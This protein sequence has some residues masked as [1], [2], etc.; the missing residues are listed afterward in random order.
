VRPLRARLETSRR[1][2]GLPWEV[3]EEIVAEKLRAL[4]QHARSL[5]ERGWSRSR[6]RDYYDLWRI[7][8]ACRGDLDL[9]GFPALLERKCAVR[10]VAF[11]GV[12]D[13][14]DPRVVTLVRDT[15]SQ[16][17]GPLVSPLPDVDTVLESLRA[18]MTRSIFNSVPRGRAT[19]E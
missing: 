2:S 14:F 5:E 7:F 13:F 16:W 18:E 10:S 3:L 12:A 15:W 4:L 9:T 11:A 6:A 8:G 19:R 17:L 1:D